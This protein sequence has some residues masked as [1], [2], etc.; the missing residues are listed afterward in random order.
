MSNEKYNGWTNWET[1][2]FNLH[3]CNLDDIAQDCFNDI[4]VDHADIES[5]D[6]KQDWI[7]DIKLTFIKN[8]VACI[9][10]LADEEV[11]LFL[12]KNS[13]GFFVDIINGSLRAVNFREIAEH[14]WDSID[15]SILEEV[16]ENT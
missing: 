9:E 11:D 12:G 8:L 4:D 2:L 6:D 16:E 15:K 3:Y 1:W 10:N 14:Y 5:F 7:D 13:N